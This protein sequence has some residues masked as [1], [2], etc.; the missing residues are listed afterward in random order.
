MKERRPNR[1]AEQIVAD[2]EAKIASV[3]ARE[4]RKKRMADPVVKYARG[5]SKLIE[6]G[7][8]AANDP[9][10]KKALQDALL[11]VNGCVGIEGG[12]MLSTVVERVEARRRGRTPKAAP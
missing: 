9:V 11:A 12:E 2:L 8:A 5:A 3:R 6:K 7:I 1:S 10:T 4:E